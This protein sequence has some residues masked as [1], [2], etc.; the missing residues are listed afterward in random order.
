M[1]DAREQGF[2]II[3]QAGAHPVKSGLTPLFADLIRRGFITLFATNMASVIHTFELALTGASSERVPAV[4]PFG[5]FGMA[6]ETGAYLNEMIR[7]A[8]R[9]EIG[10]GEGF[11]RLLF[12][13]EF[14]QTVL[15]NVFKEL[16]DSPEYIKPV[17]GFP[18][19]DRTLFAAA[20]EAGIPVTIHAMIGTDITDQH[21]NFDGAAK[22]ATSARDFLIYAEHIAR[23]TEGGIALNVASAVLGP[24]VLLK[25]ASM[26]ANVG[27][28]MRAPIT[29]T[30]DIRPA[31]PENAES[32][33][34]AFHYYFRDQKTIAS[35]VP[36]CF[37][38]T[39][40]YF[41]GDFR[42]TFVDLYKRIRHLLGE[43]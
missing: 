9:L 16:P 37:G 24:E 14:R 32:D 29:A 11:E 3:L 13:S 26:A 21:Q 7:E 38:G 8:Q 10:L 33:E 15:N 17:Q 23:F 12:D 22:G 30:F 34:S 40:Y 41:Q 35:R 27:K 1:M 4:L 18:H 42:D 20:H 19:A 2:P 43:N 36:S 31:M 6:F 5:D 25:A 28:P 39:G